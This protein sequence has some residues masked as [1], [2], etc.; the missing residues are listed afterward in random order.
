M[1]NPSGHEVII[2]NA[3]EQMLR[4][5]GTWDKFKKREFRI[6]GVGPEKSICLL[7]G[8]NGLGDSIH[9]L[10]AIWQKIHDGFEVTVYARAFDRPIF[11]AIGCKF[12]DESLQEGADLSYYGAIYKLFMWLTDH[13]ADCG[14][15]PIQLTRFEQF[16]RLI[17][18]TVPESF[19]F[20][21]YLL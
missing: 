19:D 7:L 14:A 18:T 10:P 16:A 17:D 20:R 8:G 2:N 5:N 13:E 4:G 15:G 3:T 9:A 12:F 6:P 1:I 21:K 11:E